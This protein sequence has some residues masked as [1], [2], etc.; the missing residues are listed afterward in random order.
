VR[1][2]RNE[3]AALRSRLEALEGLERERSSSEVAEA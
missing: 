1:L 2:L 3:N